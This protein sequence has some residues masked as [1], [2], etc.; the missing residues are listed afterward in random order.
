[1]S[2]DTIAR[3]VFGVSHKTI[4]ARILRAFD[5]ATPSDV[6]A[7]AR[8]YD[9]AGDLAIELAAQHG[10]TVEKTASVIAALSPRTTWTRNVAGA[11]A[12]IADNVVIPG[13][14][15]AN[16]DRARQTLV[17]GYAGLGNGPKTNAFAR[18][19]A[20]DREVV[21]V[22]VWAARVADLDENLLSRKGAYAAVA[23]AYVV[24]ARRRGVDPA[25][26]QATTWIVARSG[27]AS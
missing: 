24:A 16:V 5:A 17:D 2:H 4:V 6:E 25:T 13:L 21:T 8:W 12:L 11:V 20:G 10:L 7:G 19:I 18:N 3:S 15:G 22:D 26:M 23:H 1:M 14:I 9:E 27:R